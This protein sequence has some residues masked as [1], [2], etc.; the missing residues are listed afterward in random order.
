MAF[1]P[2]PATRIAS[3]V[4]TALLQ[5]NPLPLFILSIPDDYELDVATDKR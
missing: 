5:G 4:K 3:K 2:F 1:S